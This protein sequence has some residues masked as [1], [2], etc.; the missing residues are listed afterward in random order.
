MKK[1][2][3][4]LLTVLFVSATPVFADDINGYGTV[5]ATKLNVRQNPSAD[6]KI[7]GALYDGSNVSVVTK[8]GEWYKIE[9]NGEIGFVHSDYLAVSRKGEV[10][11]KIKPQSEEGK[12]KAQ[13]A[14]DLALEYL[15]M[16]YL[17]GGATPDGF[18]CSGLVYYV[19]G[20]LGVKLYRV[21]ADQNKNG[22]PVPLDKLE[23]G[24][25][26]FFWNRQYYSEINH[27]GIY[28][29]DGQF[30]HAPQTG[31]VVKITDIDSSYYKKNIYSARRI[32][33]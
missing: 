9:F 28:I 17:W 27:V 33:E 7:I 14:V 6:A 22:I 26:V 15:G 31:D 19:Y 30:V 11:I 4:L 20:E 12:K 5:Y 2:L 18:D 3:C 23:P 29:G 21:A 25:L 16:P 1:L 10:K 8:T 13:E 24:D 32:F